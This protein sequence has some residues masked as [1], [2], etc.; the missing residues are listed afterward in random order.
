MSNRHDYK[1]NLEVFQGPLDLLLFLIKKKKIDIQDIPIASITREYLQYLEQKNSIN[2]EREG[3]FLFMATLLIYI[4]SQMLLPREEIT[5][6]EDPRRTLVNRLQEYQKIKAACSVLKEKE[7]NQK[8]KWQ[9]AS[10]PSSKWREEEEF[11]EVSLFDLAEAF[12]SLMKRK[13]QENIQILPSK[14]V[15]LEEKM[16][17][18]RNYFQKHSYLDF[19]DYFNQQETIEEALISFFCLLEFIKTKTVMAV[20]EKPFHPIKVWFCNE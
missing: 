15:S 10:L 19:F 18:M 13:E 2:L 4:K 3:E 8:L 7:E 1:V 5:N 9:R 12:F 6:E 17:E 16:K 14:E 20:Q 11:M